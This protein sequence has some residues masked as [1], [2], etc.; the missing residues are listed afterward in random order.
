MF[1]RILGVFKLDKQVFK[2][3]EQDANATSQAAIVVVLVAGLSAIG[4]LITYLMSG[5]GGG[6]LLGN[7]FFPLVWAFVGWVVWS[8][9]TFLIGTKLFGGEATLQEMLRLIGFAYAPQLLSII[10]CVGGLI[11][12]IWS[13]I[14]SFFAIREGLDL[15][16]GKT[17]LTV[18]LGW[19]LIFILNWVLGSLLGIG[20]LATGALPGLLG[21]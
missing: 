15:D 1:Q 18:G 21:G 19:L 3:I 17:L 11:G 13:L 4:G 6:N 10:P 12:A 7:V 9:A 8:A 14:A 20:A 5:E 2:E 16:T